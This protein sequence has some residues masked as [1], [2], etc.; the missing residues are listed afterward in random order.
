MRDTGSS[1]SSIVNIRAI[2]SAAWMGGPPLATLIIGGF[3]G[4]G[5][6]VALVLLAVL[7]IATTTAMITRQ[8]RAEAAGSA[9]TT[10]RAPAS[11]PPGARVATVTVLAAF[12]LFQATNATAMT[13]MTIYVT[14][15]MGLAILWAGITLGIA[16]AL[17]VP[18]LIIVGR[19]GDRVSHLTLIAVGAIAGIAYYLGLAVVTGPVVLLLLQ[20]L[21][22][23]CFA[24][25]SGIGLA[26]FQD[27]I[28]GAGLSTGLYMNTRRVGSIL[29]G[30]IIALGALPPLGQRGIFVA[31]A[32]LTLAGLGL[33]HLARRA[34][35]RADAVRSE[36]EALARIRE[37]VAGSLYFAAACSRIWARA[38]LKPSPQLL[39]PASLPTSTSST[40]RPTTS[41]GRAAAKR[42]W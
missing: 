30:P 9:P 16:A 33:I 6:L 11:L 15:A 2:I 42:S 40:L 22:A 7:N 5:V 18:A 24:S 34:G 10:P 25:I 4:Y 28:P 38:S 14:E 41:S 3:G 32:V 39:E 26:L 20:L 36:E 17:E 12:V 23:V 19:L 13:F 8:R 31:C 29:S 35:G 37:Q 1:T 27:L 21:N